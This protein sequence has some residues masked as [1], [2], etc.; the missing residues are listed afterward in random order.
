MDTATN[1]L[2][3]F[4]VQ[5]T[6]NQS[7]PGQSISLPQWSG[8]DQKILWSQSSAYSSLCPSL[9][10]AFGAMLGKQWFTHYNSS[11]VG[12]GTPEGRSIRRHQKLLGI[13]Q[14]HL[15]A[16]LNSSLPY[17]N[18]PYSSLAFHWQ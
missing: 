3:T 17:C 12:H 8:P 11:R 18:F 7:S 10:A 16:L 6:Y 4:L 9:L 14:W 15:P 1:A 5:A 13:Q 2:L